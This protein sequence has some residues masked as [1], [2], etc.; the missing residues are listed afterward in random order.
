[1]KLNKYVA[2][3]VLACVASTLKSCIYNYNAMQTG[4]D[5]CYTCV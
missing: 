5:G 4:T 3:L 1:M 2:M